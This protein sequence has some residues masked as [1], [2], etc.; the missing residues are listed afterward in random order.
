MVI[1]HYLIMIYNKN[2]TYGLIYIYNLAL[3]WGWGGGGGV[4]L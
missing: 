1:G 2:H 3:V 4:L